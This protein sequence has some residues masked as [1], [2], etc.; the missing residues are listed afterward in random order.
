MFNEQGQETRF[1]RAL[2]ELGSIAMDKF[3]PEMKMLVKYSRETTFVGEPTP[4]DKKDKTEGL[5]QRHTVDY[6]SY[7]RKKET[8][9]KQKGQLFDLLMGVLEPNLKSKV[10]ANSDYPDMEATHDVKGLLDK[11]ND[12]IFM[13]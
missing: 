6:R 12:M 8:Y 11:L 2:D 10:E 7:E 13:H 1:L 5:T 3:G 9:H 4:P